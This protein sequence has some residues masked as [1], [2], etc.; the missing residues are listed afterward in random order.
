ME[1]RNTKLYRVWTS[2]KARVKNKNHPAY[3]DYGNRGITIFS[4]WDEDFMAFYN[5]AMANGYQEGLSIDRINND[6]S[7]EP[8]NCRW[9]TSK[10]QQNN[11]RKHGNYGA[12][13]NTSKVFFCR[14]RNKWRAV[15]SGKHIGYFNTE[16]EAIA[17]KKRAHS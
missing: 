8:S 7:Y 9:T 14:T 17:A 11:R 4:R 12:K 3:K 16:Q 10:I 2:I 6:G 13:I 1:R 5:W 15:L